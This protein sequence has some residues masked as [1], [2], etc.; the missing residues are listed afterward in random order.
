MILPVMDSGSKCPSGSYQQLALFH[1]RTPLCVTD[2]LKQRAAP[3]P[4]IQRLGPFGPD[5]EGLSKQ[6]PPAAGLPVL[7]KT[8]KSSL[9]TVGLRLALC[10]VTLW[11]S[12]GRLLGLASKNGKSELL[13]V[14]AQQAGFLWALSFSQLTD[15]CTLAASLKLHDVVLHEP[16]TL[17][18][19]FHSD[20]LQ[21]SFI[22]Q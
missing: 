18:N 5:R 16:P 13:W 7:W 21:L 1:G 14:S 3:A 22:D 20:F 15:T 6:R 4:V 11:P 19:N 2:E 12:A 17:Q 9:F 8:L 10:H